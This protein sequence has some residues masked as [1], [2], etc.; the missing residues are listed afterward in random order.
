MK[1]PNGEDG[2]YHVVHDLRPMRTV[3]GFFLY[4]E[5][6]GG[7]L[8]VTHKRAKKVRLDALLV[9]RGLVEDLKSAKAW[10]MSGDVIVDDIRE[11]KP[12]TLIRPEATIRMRGRNI[13]FASRGGLKLSAA[14][15]AFRVDVSGRIILDAG[16]STGGFTDCL[17]SRGAAR[18]Y[19]VDVGYGQL[20]GKLRQDPRV[21]NM[22]RTNIGDIVLGQLDPV[23]DMGVI[24]LSYLS[25]SVAIPT[26]ARLLAP[27]VPGAEPEIIALIKPLFEVA[28]SGPD[29]TRE[30]YRAAIERGLRAGEGIGW[31]ARGVMASPVLGSGGTL[32]FL[33]HY[34]LGK[35]H[36]DLYEKIDEAVCSGMQLVKNAGSPHNR[37]GGME[38]SDEGNE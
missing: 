21:V 1:R 18:V 16:A 11:D 38:E 31:F 34:S 17:L 37:A 36:G 30:Q 2:W 25:L 35:V 27:S 7:G 32:E 33:A 23:P 24:D 29:L 20:T 5:L 15:D 3:V 8:R 22:E 9:E 4:A 12:G 14:L 26:V 10:I 6:F 28:A 19:A 13:P